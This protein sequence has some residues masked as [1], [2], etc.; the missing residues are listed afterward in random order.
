MK[1][2]TEIKIGDTATIDGKEGIVIVSEPSHKGY[3]V[4]IQTKEGDKIMCYSENPNAK[5]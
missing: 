2:L 3:K 1:R 4:V 5:L